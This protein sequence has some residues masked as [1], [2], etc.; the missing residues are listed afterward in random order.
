MAKNS[1]IVLHKDNN[2]FDLINKMDSV[3]I[4]DECRLCQRLR[5]KMGRNKLGRILKCVKK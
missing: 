3:D 1:Q 5:Q 2:I 4:N